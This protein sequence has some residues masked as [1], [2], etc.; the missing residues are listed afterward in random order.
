M[1]WSVHAKGKPADVA[2]NVA[3][4]IAQQNC[5]EPEQT[6]KAKA[7]DI[8][9]FA[10]AAFPDAAAVKVEASGHQG[11]GEG[12]KYANTLRIDITPT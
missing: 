7:G 9:A 4:N 3:D 8:I 6:I 1:S 11:S 2:K 5:V 10:L 12:G